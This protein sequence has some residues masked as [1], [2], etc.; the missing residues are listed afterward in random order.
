MLKEGKPFFSFSPAPVVL[1]FCLAKLY[2]I[3]LLHMGSAL[4]DLGA[5]GEFP[6]KS[7]PFVTACAVLQP[8]TTT[9]LCSTVILLSD[10]Y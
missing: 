3:M 4:Y 8:I 10:K 7:I 5:G 9:H 6:L 1:R 2:F